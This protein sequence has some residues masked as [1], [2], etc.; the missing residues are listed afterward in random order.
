MDSP[1][2][3]HTSNQRAFTYLVGIGVSHSIAPSVHDYV[4]KALGYSWRFL[5]QE[6][7]TV[8]EAVALFRKPTFA[9]GVVT[10]PYKT[11]IMQHLDG[12][13]D[14][15]IRIGACNNVYRAP[16][17]SLRG[18][19]TDWRGI[20]G[21]LL[22]QSSGG[23]GRPAMIVGA[24]GASRAALFALHHQLECNPVYVVNRDKGEVAALQ[25]DVGIYDDGPEIVHIT[26]V[27]QAQKLEHPFYIVGTVP[28]FEP[29]SAA[30]LESHKI[31]EHFISTRAEK[32]VL[33]DMCFKPRRTRILKLGETYEWPTV[34]GIGVIGHQIRE[35]Y[36]LW[37]GDAQ[38]E[39]V[40]IDGAW[41]VLHKAAD[42]STAINF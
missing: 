27:D 4:A 30:E 18:T 11:T 6:C 15:A 1:D 26:S 2:Q 14:Y 10:M 5:A 7:P 36:R 37:C 34:E 31:L 3:F 20:K 9:G 13:D 21:C 23:Q 42:E 39:Q 38:S 40:P 17:G 16:D 41:A 8:E 29:T 24:G 12:L 28:D 33:L 22:D 19:N 35:Q 32:G 25:R